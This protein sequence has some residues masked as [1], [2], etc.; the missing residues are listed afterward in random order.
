MHR[1]IRY[2]RAGLCGIWSEQPSHETAARYNPILLH[3]RDFNKSFR[4]AHLHKSALRGICA[5]RAN[6][7][8]CIGCAGDRLLW[9]TLP[10]GNLSDHVPNAQIR[11]TF[12]PERVR[13]G[14]TAIVLRTPLME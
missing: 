13:Q 12:R 8:L 3:A 9:R 7:L 6:S 11:G 1:N 14:K 2:R 4:I 5:G 10:E